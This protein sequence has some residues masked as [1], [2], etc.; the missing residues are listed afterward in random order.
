MQA[1]LYCHQQQTILSYEHLLNGP[2]R[3]CAQVSIVG[4]EIPCNLKLT[5]ISRFPAQEYLEREVSGIPAKLH[6]TFI[7]GAIQLTAGKN[8]EIFTVSAIQ[9]THSDLK[10]CQSKSTAFASVHNVHFSHRF[11][12]SQVHSPPRSRIIMI[13]MG[14]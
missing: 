3:L 10:S 14:T 5:L 1:F 12:A 6:F 11:H 4:L 13:R 9:P 8:V 2:K 7:Q